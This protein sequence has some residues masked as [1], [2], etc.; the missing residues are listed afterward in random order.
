MEC[1]GIKGKIVV[2]DPT[3]DGRMCGV[4]ETNCPAP[5]VA[6]AKRSHQQAPSPQVHPWTLWVRKGKV[7][8]MLLKDVIMDMNYF[9]SLDK[10]LR[11]SIFRPQLPT[12][13]ATMSW[14]S[15]GRNRSS[16]SVCRRTATVRD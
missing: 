3:A 8:L 5:L 11:L 1:V 14:S 6:S 2:A 7:L 4:W 9:I 13:S 15:L 10:Y 12:S 16:T